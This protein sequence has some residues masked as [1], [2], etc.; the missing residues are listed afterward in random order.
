[1]AVGKDERYAFLL[2]DVTCLACGTNQSMFTK[3]RVQTD[4]LAEY[5]KEDETCE[6][7]PSDVPGL[8]T[9]CAR[10]GYS[11]IVTPGEYSIVEPTP[12][13]PEIDENGN[14]NRYPDKYTFY[15]CEDYARELYA[16]IP[17]EGDN[18]VTKE[19]VQLDMVPIGDWE[20]C[21]FYEFE[22]E[23]PHNPGHMQDLDE[24]KEV[25][26]MSSSI[27]NAEDFLNARG[28]LVL[29]QFSVKIRIMTD[30]MVTF[31]ENEKANNPESLWH[32][33]PE[34]YM[35]KYAS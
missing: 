18:M 25:E 12:L 26:F 31:G 8:L 28:V 35:A 23:D 9:K 15:V 5:I 32:Q 1:M 13:T 27:K 3:L 14:P 20:K 11:N 6:D 24:R 19:N 16:G 7:S 22:E 2:K 17:R 30:D 4:K 34:C 21:S 10:K 33:I 29:N